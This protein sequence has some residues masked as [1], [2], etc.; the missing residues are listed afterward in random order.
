MDGDYQ[1]TSAA[2]L[3]RQMMSE[4]VPKSERE[5]W[6]KQEIERLRE[7]L[8]GRGRRMGILNHNAVIATTW[9]EEKFVEMQKWV[10][11]QPN[12][13]F[14]L[15]R[16]VD[17]TRTGT[18]TLIPDGSKEEWIESKIGDDLRQKFIEQLEAAAFDDG[19]NS[20]DWVEVGFGEYGQ[21]VLR[22]NNRNLW[23]DGDYHVWRDGDYHDPTLV[24]N[25]VGTP[26]PVI[27][28][29]TLEQ[30]IAGVINRHSAENGSNTPD[31]LLAAYLRDCLTA[32]N[33]VT[34][35]RDEWWKNRSLA[36][37][38]NSTVGVGKKEK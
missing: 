7:V 9:S 6:A 38:A 19:S 13:V 12:V 8:K 5:W 36:G 37:F 3:E 11:G 24:P 29:F 27:E 25:D 14:F 35:A 18:I 32:F 33:Q 16:W 15:S 4:S 10:V 21:K 20:W 17:K 22:G 31:F 1:A 26:P 28:P 23:G 2:E 34:K 30:E